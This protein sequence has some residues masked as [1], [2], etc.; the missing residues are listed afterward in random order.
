M[1]SAAPERA[2]GRKKSDLD[3]L[4]NDD[5]DDLEDELFGSSSSSKH[6]GRPRGGSGRSGS[7][8]ARYIPPPAGA[9]KDLPKSLGKGDVLQVVAQNK[10]ALKRCTSKGAGAHGKLVMAWRILPSGRVTGVR[11]VTR[12]FQS[13]PVCACLKST[14]KKFKFPPYGGPQM[15]PIEFPFSF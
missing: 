3:D 14:I 8:P 9:K 6:G 2:R 7:R 15:P 5:G 4:F 13:S 12:E 10:S 1:A 11:C